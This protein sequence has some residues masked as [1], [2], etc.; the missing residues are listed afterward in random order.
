MNYYIFIILSILSFSARYVVDK[1]VLSKK[2]EDEKSYLAMLGITYIFYS[3]IIAIFLDW[4]GV[5]WSDLILPIITGIGLTLNMIIYAKLLKKEDISYVAGIEYTYPLIVVILSFIFLNERFG[6]MAYLGIL[7]MIAGTFVISYR[8]K[9]IKLQTSIWLFISL[10]IVVG[11]IDFV[12]KISTTSLDGL[13]GAL[14]MLTTFGLLYSIYLMK[15]NWRSVSTKIWKYTSI[16]GA[17]GLIAWGSFFLAMSGLP[18]TIVSSIA[19]TQALF[20]MIIEFF[21]DRY[22]SKISRDKTL[23]YKA[24]GILLIISG[25][26]L[27]TFYS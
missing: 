19:T 17:L 20:V 8:L 26:V 6:V 15:G 7:L 22:F 4:T 18:A 25:V 27:L 23:I 9:K 13:K 5:E 10:V 1:Y 2:V 16:T 3:A 11:L 21:T 12:V 24:L 14:I